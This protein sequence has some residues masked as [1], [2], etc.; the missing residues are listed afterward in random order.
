MSVVIDR[1]PPA[2]IEAE[3][4]VLGSCLMDPGAAA[5]VAAVLPP[6]AFT[7]PAH[8]TLW[9]AILRLMEQGRTVDFVTV[10]EELRHSGE[11]D[12]VGGLKAL[13]DLVAVVPTAVHVE[14][15]A[16]LVAE[17][18]MRR[19]LIQAAARIAQVAYDEERDLDEVR[20]AI[21]RELSEAERQAAATAI[22]APGDRATRLVEMVSEIAERRQVGVSTG[23]AD[24]DRALHG[25]RPGQMVVV[26]ARPSIG[27]TSLIQGICRHVA[28]R[29]G[30]VLLCS[31]EMSGDELIARDAASIMRRQWRDVETT[32]A[33]GRADE[34]LYSVLHRVT[35]TIGELP[36]YVY[37]NPRMTTGDIRARAQEVRAKAGLSLVA[38]DYLQLLRD[39]D[40]SRDSEN[41]RVSRVSGNLKAIAGELRVPVIVASQLNRGVE[42]RTPPVPELMDLRD[43]GSIEQDADVVLGLYRAD[44]YYEVGADDHEGGRV[45]RG[46]ARLEVLK[47]R[48]GPAPVVLPLLWVEELCE[49]RSLEA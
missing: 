5:R 44:R 45:E 3:Q 17:A 19:R 39:T 26:A 38:V 42:H 29:H 2:N 16:R 48:G 20:A 8:V 24:L 35:E 49:Y 30:P 31:A 21:W 47:Q 13:S 12:E 11:Y 25:L 4:A 33:R 46:R 36:L 27:K 28:R 10:S 43:S 7:R 41:V 9:R 32:I 34:S 15:Y 22:Q 40:G 6:E 37:Y 1:M 18:A 14:E 23:I